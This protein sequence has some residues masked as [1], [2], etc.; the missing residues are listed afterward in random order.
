MKNKLEMFIFSVILPIL[1][2]SCNQ[3]ASEIENPSNK[4]LAVL[5]STITSTPPNF[6]DSIILST[7][8]EEN[9]FENTNTSGLLNRIQSEDPYISFEVTKNDLPSPVSVLNHLKYSGAY[10]GGPTFCE[11]QDY[12]PEKSLYLSQG[13]HEDKILY[14]ENDIYSYEWNQTI[15]LYLCGLLKGDEINV[16]IIGPDGD[17][18]YDKNPESFL[19]FSSNDY[20][21]IWIRQYIP[22]GT[23]T[24]EY[25][26]NVNSDNWSMNRKFIINSPEGPR[27][28]SFKTPERES[29]YFLY[30]FEPNEL[31]TLLIYSL[32]DKGEAL[33]LFDWRQFKANENGELVFDIL[34][35]THYRW[36]PI[37]IGEKSGEVHL[38]PDYEEHN[39]LIPD[40]GLEVFLPTYEELKSMRMVLS[41]A[42]FR[43]I[44]SPEIIYYDLV[45]S[46]DEKISWTFMWC[47]QNREILEENLEHMAIDFLINEE[48]INN[49]YI[50]NRFSTNNSGQTCQP[51]NIFLRGWEKEKEYSLELKYVIDQDVFDGTNIYKAGT[52]R[53]IFNVTVKD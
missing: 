26:L 53:H 9:F 23:K 14:L 36:S 47:A 24:G 49:N 3:K 17:N 1:L 16:Q 11:Q 28:Y 44:K 25:T 45:V 33:E 8:T 4:L 41:S 39:V 50:K 10:G 12:W 20:A 15:V 46:S 43:D 13:N 32:N 35:E 52:Y 40:S 6:Q 30:N 18:F 38:F 48:L 51:Y 34:F 29:K 22:I 42:G 5:Q 2:V 19:S 7:P 27:F 31:V 37:I 21:S